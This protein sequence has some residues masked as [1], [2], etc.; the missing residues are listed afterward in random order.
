MLTRRSFLVAAGVGAVAMTVRP[1]SAATAL[2]LT[3][4]NNTGAYA[5]TSIWCYLVG[6][7]SAGNQFHVTPNGTIV[8]VSLSDNGSGGFTDYAI[9]LAPTGP[10]T[11]TV[12]RM[13][14]RLY[15]ALGQKLRFKAVT[16]GA[17]RPALQYPAGWVDSDPNY[18][19]L[20]DFVEFT[21]DD[22]GMHCNTTMVDQ[23]G[24]PL[25]IQLTGAAS[26]TTGTLKPGGRAQIFDQ[27]R[28]QPD[29]GNLV[30]DDLR[31][32]APGHGLDAGRF[33]PTYFDSYTDRV[34][35]TYTGT[36]LRLNTGSATFTGRIGS[37]GTL[38]VRDGSGRTASPI[39][40]PSTRD[41]LFCDGALAAPNDGLTGPVAALLGAALNRT[42]LLDHPDQPV[43]DPAAFYRNPVT[44]HYARI[45]HAA[46]AD[47]RAYGFAFDDVGGFA[48]YIE[49]PA[50]TSCT[51]TLTPF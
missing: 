46:T 35:S 6:T 29:F 16:D 2:P 42:T 49:D 36:D 51:V 17:G 5:N 10:T 18:R 12:P 13:S 14:G 41:I 39:R 9:P 11:L 48:S 43:S 20:H 32:I 33:S 34:W 45:M 24:V 37:D 38:V 1:A 47:G 8:P 25:S 31:V 50:P 21:L 28:A 4:V 22:L 7:D 44:N 3:I 26:Q 19:I 15:F 27:I 23:F 30:V 40:R